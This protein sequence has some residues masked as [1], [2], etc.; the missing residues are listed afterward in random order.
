MNTTAGAITALPFDERVHQPQ[1]L[2]LKRPVTLGAG[3]GAVTYRTL[4][5]RYPTP[6]EARRADGCIPGVDAAI[7]TLAL[8]AGVPQD[9]IE[10]LGPRDFLAACHVMNQYIEAR[11]GEQV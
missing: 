11:N 5:L 10:R 6:K 3:R 1:T 4:E 9:V 2:H 8:V 7:T